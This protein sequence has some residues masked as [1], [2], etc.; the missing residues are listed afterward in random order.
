LAAVQPGVIR[1]Q[2]QHQVITRL[3]GRVQHTTEVP[4][5]VL[6]HVHTVHLHQVRASTGE[7]HR[8]AA[9]TTAAEAAEAAAVVRTLQ[10]AQVV[11]SPV[12]GE[13]EEVI[14]AEVAEDHVLREVVHLLPDADK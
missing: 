4:V 2:N 5:P 12:A 6:R 10:V 14:L 3:T 8:Q 11:H 7:V 13:A 9:E 1:S